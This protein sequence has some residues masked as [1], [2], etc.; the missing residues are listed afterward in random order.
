MTSLCSNESFIYVLVFSPSMK[1]VVSV[2]CRCAACAKLRTLCC[3]PPARGCCLDWKNTD[4]SPETRTTTG[5]IFSSEQWNKNRITQNSEDK[6]TSVAG[7][8]CTVTSSWSHVYSGWTNFD[9]P[10]GWCQLLRSKLQ[11]CC[12]NVSVLHRRDRQVGS[13][14]HWDSMGERERRARPQD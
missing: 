7:T 10:D 8:W 13:S 5:G 14:C 9:R 12:V 6:E 2:S 1:A 3:Y 4:L 11:R